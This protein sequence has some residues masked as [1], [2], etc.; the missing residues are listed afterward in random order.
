[1]SREDH[2][3]DCPRI[4]FGLMFF[5]ASDSPDPAFY[6]FVLR[7]ARYA[8]ERFSFISTPERHFHP[9]G[10]AFPN[11]S[12]M[13][14]AIAAVTHRIQ[15]RAGSLIAPLHNLT[16]IAEDW[17]L[18]DNLS[19]GRV[20]IAFGTGWNVDDFVLA[21]GS[22]ADRREI[23]RQMIRTISRLWET[24]SFAAVNP[25]GRPVD[26]QLFP[27][28]VQAR[29]NGWLTVSKSREGFVMAG[30]EGLNVLTHLETQ[31]LATLAPHI[32]EYRSA[33]E[34]RGLDPA[35]G[36]VTV[37]QHTLIGDDKVQQAGREALSAYLA[38]AADLE[39]RS[40]RNGGVMS[41]GRDGAEEQA[42]IVESQVREEMVAFAGRRFLRGASLMGTLDE[43]EQQV[44]RLEEAGVNEIA[45]LIDFVG[46]QEAAWSSLA[47]LE[48][49]QA[50]FSPA[51]R[52][53]HEDSAIAR[54]LGSGEHTAGHQQEVTS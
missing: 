3:A 20:A 19:A 28:P 46:T 53:Q 26:L 7:V 1:M 25:A 12:V 18:I 29:L 10:G 21:P 8:D 32:A 22:Y 9:F 13:S 43:C 49:L 14:A 15:I 36:V 33:R 4:G 17:A 37:M 54:F 24:G 40:V 2:P 16:R 38:S 45:C 50:R 34:R 5:A 47:A 41:A 11:P 35:S 42:L 30:E 44:T 23:I 48:E 51:G 27:R 6:D 52:R 31:D 39:A